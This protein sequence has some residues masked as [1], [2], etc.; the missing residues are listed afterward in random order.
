MARRRATTAVV[1]T[2]ALATTALMAVAWFFAALNGDL[3]VFTSPFGPDL[4]LQVGIL[5]VAVI[6]A[7]RRPDNALGWLFLGCTFVG[8]VA[9]ANILARSRLRR[10]AI[11]GSPNSSA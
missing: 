2:L 5:P 11:A 7:L 1:A 8:A 3:N 9:A 10:S 6:I 4:V